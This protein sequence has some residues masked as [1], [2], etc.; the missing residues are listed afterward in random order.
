MH[1]KGIISRGKD[2]IVWMRLSEV[3]PLSTKVFTKT[4]SHQ[5]MVIT[6]G[7]KNYA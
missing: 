3:F 5:S 6:R 1:R 4:K 7:E 2:E